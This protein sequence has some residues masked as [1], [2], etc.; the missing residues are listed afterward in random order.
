VDERQRSFKQMR[1]VGYA[2]LAILFYFIFQY[3]TLPDVSLMETCF[4]TTMNKV[5]FCPKGK[6]F[7]PLKQ[8]SPHI[9][10]ALIISED[11]S[12][13]SHNGIDLDELK[14]SIETNLKERRFARGGSTLTQQLA[15]NLFLTKDKT[16]TRKVK[17][18]ILTKRIEEKYSKNKILETYLNVVEF[19]DGI[20][21][22]KKA[23]DYYF[24]KHP[25]EISPLEASF[26]I[27]LLPNPKKYSISFKKKELTKFARSRIQDILYKMLAHKK[28]SSEDYQFYKSQLTTMWQDAP[29]MEN[30]A[31]EYDSNYDVLDL[32]EQIQIEEIQDKQNE[33]IKKLQRLEEETTIDLSDPAQEEP[34]D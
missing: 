29:D 19:G 6:S 4:T 24:Q 32:N 21:G 1:F 11:S 7:T 18:F 22:V 26:L 2:V 27:F 13:Y 14:K 34:L 9:L 17:E 20:Y 16:I 25:S 5:D 23:S 12:F 10:N 8:I 30:E 15:K 28:I 3:A 31:E 33:S